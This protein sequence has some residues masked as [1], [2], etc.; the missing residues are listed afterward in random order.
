MT[1]AKKNVHPAIQP[2]YGIGDTEKSYVNAFLNRNL[3]LSGYYG[4]TRPEFFGGEE[5]K[6]FEK[7]WRARFNCSHALAVNSATSGLIAALGAIGIGPGDEVIVS[8]YSMSASAI[9]PLFYGGIPVF[10]DLE[11]E[12]FGFDLHDVKRKIT[13]KTKAI[14]AVNLFGHPVELIALRHLCDEKGL[15]LIEDNAQGV[16]AQEG[17]ALAGT[18]GD[19]GVFSLNVHKHIQCG[20][21]GVCVTGNDE[22]ALRIQL[23]RNHGENV[24]EWAGAKE[25]YNLLG[26]NFR[27][28]EMAA[29]VARAQLSRID[30]LV[31]RCEHIAKRLTEGVHGLQ[32]IIPPQVRDGCRHVYFMW[33]ARLLEKKLG[34]SRARFCERLSELGLTLAQGYVPPIYRLP[35]FREK[36]GIG[37]GGFPFNLGTYDYCNRLCPTVER[38]HEDELIQF[39]PVSWDPTEEQ[40]D[41]MIEAFHIVYSELCRG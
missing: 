10:A 21:G 24:A 33:S 28:S 26:Y 32:G 18:V 38:L 36:A 40:I 34:V 11:D 19:I 16:L 37:R 31:G 6:Q 8:S 2:F 12:F 14:I 5:V 1:I 13:D 30:E 25:F 41:Q 39:Q 27:M 35:V 3:P 22:L 4:S 17:E 9:A 15:Y 7:E 23:I 29:A 20:E